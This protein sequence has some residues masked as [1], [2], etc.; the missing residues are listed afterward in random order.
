MQKNLTES[1]LKHHFE[2]F[3]RQDLPDLLSDY[4]ENALLLVHEKCY[5]GHTEISVFFK[6]FMQNQLVAESDF[7]LQVMQVVDNLG[8]IVWR[9][10]TPTQ[11]FE[12]ATD[13]F[14]IQD[15]KI[16]Q[17]TFARLLTSKA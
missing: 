8:Y 16:Q 15:G 3:D 1:I 7:E 9:A 13:T 10:T 12:M 5:Q 11:T 17:Q 2:A 14:V 4:A 6:D